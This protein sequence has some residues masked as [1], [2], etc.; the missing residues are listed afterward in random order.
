MV[1]DNHIALDYLL[2][3]QGGVCTLANTS[4]CFY[5]NSTGQIEADVQTILK[6]ATWLWN[7]N[8]EGMKDIIWNTV[9]Q[10]FP[11]L[12]WFLPLLDRL[13][14]SHT[15][16]HLWSLHN[17]QTNNFSFL[18]DT[19]NTSTNDDSTRLSAHTSKSIGPGYTALPLHPNLATPDRE[20]GIAGQHS[21]MSNS[22]EVESEARLASLNF[23]NEFD[24]YHLKGGMLE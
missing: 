7:F 23:P 5:I 20:Q 19:G 14:N 9:K 8:L 10:A 24:R 16:L 15:S 21:S 6:H 13:I 17:E 11:N 2:A 1:T 4:C 3:S 12:T 18:P 22:A